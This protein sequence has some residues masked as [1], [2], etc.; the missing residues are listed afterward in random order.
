[1]PTKT[2][3]YPHLQPKYRDRTKQ[4]ARA[5]AAAVDGAE[6]RDRKGLERRVRKSLQDFLVNAE[7]W[8]IVRPA[9]ERAMLKR[10]AKAIRKTP[11]AAR[12]AYD[13]LDWLTRLI[14]NPGPDAEIELDATLAERIEQQLA[15]P[16]RSRPQ[17]T[18]QMARA[19]LIRNLVLAFDF[20][21]NAPLVGKRTS[22]L[23]VTPGLRDFIR[24]VLTPFGLLDGRSRKSRGRAMANR[25]LAREIRRALSLWNIS[26]PSSRQRKKSAITMRDLRRL[27]DE[28]ISREKS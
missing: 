5:V 14:L 7:S 8:D 17:P 18:T 26:P 10:L 11:E 4:V 22:W 20:Y 16:R 9:N 19:T 23:S 28:V 2:Q 1:M 15:R 24:V 3:P 6:W 25:E 12:D 21:I 27:A 13:G